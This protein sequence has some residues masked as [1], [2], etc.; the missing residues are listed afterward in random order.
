[1]NRRE[2]FKAVGALPL[3]LAGAACVKAIGGVS[4]PAGSVLSNSIVVRQ[5][6]DWPHT[7]EF[8]TIRE[9]WP[10]P[11]QVVKISHGDAH[12]SG[13]VTLAEIQEMCHGYFA[14]RVWG[15]VTAFRLPGA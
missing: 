9:P 7:F 1:M 3:A 2:M 10:R 4:V 5:G 15:I 12:L 8:V 6:P 14:C 13:E 11:G